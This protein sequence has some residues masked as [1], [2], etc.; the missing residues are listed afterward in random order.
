V[1][2]SM[3]RCLAITG[4]C[5]LTAPLPLRTCHVLTLLKLMAVNEKEK[6]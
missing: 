4:Y 5:E 2:D 1:S 3:A 6:R